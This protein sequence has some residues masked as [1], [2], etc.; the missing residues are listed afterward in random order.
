M[1]TSP[2]HKQDVPSTLDIAQFYGKD[3]VN[4]PQ[5]GLEGW[6]NCVL[7]LDCNVSVKYLLQHLRVRHKA[8]PIRD[9]TLE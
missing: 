7:P 8:F 9:I 2:V 1:K 4:H 6:P 3:L 5:E